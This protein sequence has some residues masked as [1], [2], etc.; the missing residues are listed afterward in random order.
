MR[1]RLVVTMVLA[2]GLL[3]MMIAPVAAK[4]LDK[5]VGVGVNLFMQPPAPPTVLEA[6]EA[7]HVLHGWQIDPSESTSIGQLDFRLDIDGVDQ[8]KGKLLT[9]GVGVENPDIFL[10]K[11]VMSR[12]WL[13]NFEDGLDTGTYL[14]TGHW[15]A[16]C[17]PSLEFGYPGPCGTPNEPIEALTVSL[18]V[19]VN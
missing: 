18:V 4:P 3:G 8:G 10:G 19:T 5:P 15:F 2:V 12:S 6:G 16:P 13:Y 7:F 11:G 9:I 1:R 14:F 17:R